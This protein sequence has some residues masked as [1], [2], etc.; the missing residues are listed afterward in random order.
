MNMVP[1]QLFFIYGVIIPIRISPSAGSC[2]YKKA[3]AA[4]KIR[5]TR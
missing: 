4:G 5:Y 1:L 3:L 2:G